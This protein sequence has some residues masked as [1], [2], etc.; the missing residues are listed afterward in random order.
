VRQKYRLTF[1]QRTFLKEEGLEGLS[2][3]FSKNDCGALNLRIVGYGGLPFCYLCL[4]RV[5]HGV[6]QKHTL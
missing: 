6:N 1:I 2:L 3:R 5:S 4:P